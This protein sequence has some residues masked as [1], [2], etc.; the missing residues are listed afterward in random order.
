MIWQDGGYE[1]AS[2]TSSP[3][4]DA[5]STRFVGAITDTSLAEMK[6][7]IH[8][9]FQ[10]E[11]DW[12][13]SL[14][15]E[16]KTKLI[17]RW[18]DTLGWEAPINHICFTGEIALVL[19]G[20]TPCCV[21]SSD[22]DLEYGRMFYEQVLK[23]WY[24]K[25]FLGD[26]D[27]VCEMSAPEVA[28]ANATGRL[29]LP[30]QVRTRTEFG[31]SAVFRND[32]HRDAAYANGIFSRPD[33]IVG[34]EELQVCFGFPFAHQGTNLSTIMYQFK[35]PETVFNIDECCCSPCL[36]YN[37]RAADAGAVGRHFRRC[38]EAMETL[39][40]TI[41]LDIQNQEREEGNSHFWPAIAIGTAFF[42]AAGGSIDEFH[43]MA[44]P[45][46][47]AL[48]FRCGDEKRRDVLGT[49][50]LRNELSP[51]LDLL[52]GIIITHVD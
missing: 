30:R 43:A 34:E 22:C 6:D 3:G 37:A 16:Q 31:N 35:N 24:D 11:I 40:Y 42:E 17:P 45:D 4:D 44:Q 36:Q 12:L 5:A 28:Y 15:N 48:W 50:F 46:V 33:N 27:F 32:A 1:I 26:S 13:R 9:L 19:A 38:R 18:N 39:G 52:Q 7:I 51:L 2:N 49:I 8:E 47:D 25:Y 29:A 14:S 21:V 20:I 23:P 10:T 41:M